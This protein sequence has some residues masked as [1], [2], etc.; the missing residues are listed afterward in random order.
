MT[1]LGITKGLYI[2]TTLNTILAFFVIFITVTAIFFRFGDMNDTALFLLAAVSFISLLGAVLSALVLRPM[3][4][5]N[6]RLR[7]QEISLGDLNRLNNTL[8]AQRHDFMNHLQVVHSL[9]ELGKYNEANAYIEKVYD[10]IEKVN[11]I[12]K[13]GIP[14]VNA[15][16]E[17]KRRTG[18]GK[19][20]EMEMDIRSDLEEIPIPEWELCR[21]LGN[22]IDNAINALAGKEGNRKI[23]IEICED[24][25]NYRF[26][27]A[28]NGPYIL[29]SHLGKLFEPGFTTR[30]NTGEGMGLAI[31]KGIIDRY[32]GEINVI[33][34]TEETAF[35]TRVPRAGNFG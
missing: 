34:D 22:I 18:E 32:G 17:A 11:S 20:I 4:V 15:I 10:R 14:A 13:T 25:H 26:K 6:A 23:Y 28:N 3:S 16:L 30:Q 12:L 27:V 9:M 1:R 21:F 29:P 19:N 2:V 31:C 7:Q 8:R 33:S 35:E 24:I 5:F